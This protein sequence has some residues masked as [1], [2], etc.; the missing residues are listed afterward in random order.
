MP[1][2]SLIRTGA[3]P[4]VPVRAFNT[5]P[6]LTRQSFNDECNINNIM[7]KFKKTGI[8]EHAKEHQGQYGDFT[9]VTDYHTALNHVLQAQD[10]F[11]SL[12]AQLRAR[13]GNDPGE[14]LQFTDDPDNIDEMREMGLLPLPNASEEIDAAIVSEATVDPGKPVQGDA[15]D[16]PPSTS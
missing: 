7:A 11:M 14:F 2:K 9:E 12:P 8:I 6:S 3:T 5:E 10:S 16:P 13:F 1:P 4:S 15:E